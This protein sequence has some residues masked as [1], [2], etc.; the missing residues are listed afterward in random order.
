MV[1][2]GNGFK[3]KEKDGEPRKRMANLG[4]GW[5]TKEMDCKPRKW[6][7]NQG[8]GCQTKEIDG[9]LIHQNKFNRNHDNRSTM[10]ANENV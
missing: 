7:V 4:N 5:Q 10:A 8:N 6:V 9:K 2:Q 3:T 1:N